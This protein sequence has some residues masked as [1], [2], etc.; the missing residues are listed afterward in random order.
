MSFLQIDNA[1]NHWKSE[2]FWTICE[3]CSAI[4]THK[5]YRTR[6][7]LALEWINIQIYLISLSSGINHFSLIVYI[8]I[9]FRWIDNNFKH[10]I[11]WTMVNPYLY[12]VWPWRAWARWSRHN[13]LRDLFCLA[14]F[15]IVGHLI[16]CF[17]IYHL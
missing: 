13:R 14:T 3:L 9:V 4:L 5:R 2:S 12:L 15:P 1:S 8:F 7:H 16:I 11:Y 10:T 17:L 6:V